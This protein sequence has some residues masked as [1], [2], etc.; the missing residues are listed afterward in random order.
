MGMMIIRHKVTT[1]AGARSSMATSKCRGR[2]ALPIRASSTRLI[3]IRAKSWWSS[4]RGHAEGQSL[5]CLARPQGGD[6][7]GRCRGHANN[8]FP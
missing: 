1:A 8:L 3:A 5:R 2:R 6:V 4:I 7:K